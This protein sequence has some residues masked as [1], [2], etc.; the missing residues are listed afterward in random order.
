[1][2]SKSISRKGVGVRLPSLALASSRARV[3]PGLGRELAELLVPHLRS[4]LASATAT[5]HSASGS[6]ARALS[7]ERVFARLER[8]HAR[9][10]QAGWCLGLLAA[11]QGIDLL[12][13]RHEA[14]GLAWLI[15]FVLEAV[16]A[17]QASGAWPVLASATLSRSDVVRVAWCVQRAHT[18]LVHPLR[19]RLSP[20]DAEQW[21]ELELTTLDHE[22]EPERLSHPQLDATRV[23]LH[24]GW[25]G[26]RIAGS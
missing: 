17:P 22:L 24:G 16:R 15:G 10:H 11:V 2:D 7:D 4:E 1:M 3:V 13:E 6:P 21:L 8:V 5:L 26:F 19:A 9:A 23:R 18:A 20:A 14:R 12:G 25:L